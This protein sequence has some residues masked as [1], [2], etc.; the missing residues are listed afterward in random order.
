MTYWS[1][2]IAAYEE[3]LQVLEEARRAYL[4]RSRSLLGRLRSGIGNLDAG[5]E[6]QV[7]LEE[8]VTV[9]ESVLG[10]APSLRARYAKEEGQP[11]IVVVAWIASSRGGPLG[12]L[13]LGLALETPLPHPFSVAPERWLGLARASLPNLPGEPYATDRHLDVGEGLWLRIDSVPLSGQEEGAIL[14]EAIRTAERFL[15][16]GLQ[17]LAEITKAA[18][19]L[20]AAYE[21]LRGQQDRL[22]T[23][24]SELGVTVSPSRDGKL[25]SWRGRDYLQIGNFWVGI[26]AAAMRVLAEAHRPEAESIERLA[27]SV[28]RPVGQQ[29]GYPSVVLL[30]E[31]ELRSH[32]ASEV[33]ADAFDTWL[34]WKR[35]S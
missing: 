31:E 26:D 2:L 27:R 33:I 18:N 9:R 14:A 13:R 35:E 30:D 32:S 7:V 10:E 1:P 8:G 11:A 21:T 24:A 19:P 17:V 20:L 6:A 3:E 12:A 28:G 34:A 25:G 5:G 22:T 16:G 15:E 23:S 29:N 4:D